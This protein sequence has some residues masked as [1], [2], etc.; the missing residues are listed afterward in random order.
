MIDK[1]AD[2]SAG[3]PID[4]GRGQL[5]RHAQ[6]LRRSAKLIAAIVLA[7][8]LGTLALSLLQGKSYRAGAHIVLQDDG[9][10]DSL[11]VQRRLATDKA[12][13]TSR[14]VLAQAAAELPGVTLKQLEERVSAT[15]S[16]EANLIE[17]A[18]TAGRADQAAA[19]AN[20]VARAFLT[21]RTRTERQELLRQDSTL[22][23]Q[24][25]QL[26]SEPVN[27]PTAA[28]PELSALG[29]RH[30]ALAVRLASVG[31]DLTLAEPASV[32]TRP[33]SPRPL[34][35][36]VLAFFASL[37]IAVLVALGREQLIPRARD[38]REVGRI[39]GVPVLA[40]IPEVRQWPGRRAATLLL[41]EREGFESLRTA[42]ELATPP[43]A[44]KVIVVTSATVGEG[45]STV[46]CRLGRSLMHAGQGVMLVSADL[47][48][49]T[50][51]DCVGLQN[52]LGVSDL[53]ANAA[54]DSRVVSADWVARATQTVLPS[55]P[56]G[57]DW[58]TMAMLPSG[59]PREDP[60]SLLSRDLVA[61]L[62]A[63]IRRMDYEWV[64]VDAPP[65][66]GTADAR[67]LAG[68]AD[69]LLVVSRLEVATVDQLV[70]ARE[71]LDRL[72]VKPLGVVGIGSPV[73][74]AAYGGKRSG[75]RGR[76][77]PRPP[78]LT[79]RRAG[80]AAH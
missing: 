58:A 52:G 14:T 42:V 61:S 7:V 65:L 72:E 57:F 16:P 47:R 48:R 44:Q 24:M 66:L 79:R 28:R 4:D 77:E 25:Q 74:A 41:A 40:G 51:H 2:Q 34:L 12:L 46:T 54:A 32:P 60:S 55:D 35:A 27:G 49:P 53:L 62:F 20:A 78:V 70:A 50:L 15:V 10:A 38:L 39:L 73:E 45:K 37:L 11:I 5:R 17:I 23:R 33:S 67:V 18:A 19:S 1:Q 36:T 22:Q 43:L 80:H 31:S 71:E 76:T 8:T 21:E 69:A 29:R 3:F 26:R 59:E 6:A 56:L 63:E 30:D 75:Q 68:V 13:V 9:T 64:L